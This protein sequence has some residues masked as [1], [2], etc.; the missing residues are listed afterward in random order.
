ML[1]VLI[2]DDQIPEES[3]SD[4]EVLV[5]ARENYPKAHNGFINAFAVMRQAVNTLRDG[6]DVKVARRYREALS[7]IK[8]ETFDVAIVDLGWA[9]DADVPRNLERTA[10]WQLIDAIK[11]EE[12]QH[13]ER[14]PTAQIMYSSRFETDPGLGQEAAAQGILPFYK[15]YGERFSLPLSDAPVAL[16]RK[17][18]TRVACESLRGVVKF[19]EQLRNRRVERILQSAEEGLARAT[20]RER[21]WDR[22]TLS[23]VTVG[24]LAVFA[25]IV[26][27]LFGSV[28]EGAV[29]SASGVVMAII[30]RLLYGRLDKAYT[31]IKEERQELVHLLKEL[32]G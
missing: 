3:V 15:P 14:P 18:R 32:R 22:L 2:A 16:D 10:G 1:R 29:S 20:N 27:S 19:I 6:Y 11:T 9:G 17:E 24:I 28:G 7:L 4:S 26:A 30:P 8:E 5:W 12:A 23:M 13:P 31:Q 21:Q 25:G